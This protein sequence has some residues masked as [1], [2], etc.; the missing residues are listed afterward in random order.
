MPRLRELVVAPER[1]VD[2]HDVARGEAA[3]HVVVEAREARH[4]RQHA[5]GRAIAE[6]QP[7]R[8]DVGAGP[9]EVARRVA[10]R[11][12][13]LDLEGGSVEGERARGLERP[14][15]DAA[16]VGEHAQHGIAVGQGPADLVAAVHPDRR[17]GL[18]QQQ[19]ARRVVDLRVRQQDPGHGRGADAVRALGGE[20]LELLAEVRRGVGEEPRTVRPAD[21]ERR[22]RPR[23]VRR[24]RCARP[25]TSGSGSS[26][27]GSRRRRPSR[28]S[29]RAPPR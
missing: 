17:R 18:A 21:R 28:E 22:L 11:R 26:T 13:R 3:E 8:L 27:A 15:L 19:Q 23:D 5:A 14:P 20:P 1:A 4:V 2:E 25:R 6:D 9:G 7:G 16:V 29:E 24:L 12:E 10:A